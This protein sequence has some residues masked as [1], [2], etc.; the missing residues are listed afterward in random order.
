VLALAL[1][2][3][4]ANLLKERREYH[5]MSIQ[6]AGALAGLLPLLACAPATAVEFGLLDNELRGSLDSTVSYG[7]LWRVQGRDKTNDDVNVND[8]NRNFNP[9]TVSEVYKLTSDLEIS[10]KNVGMFLRGSGYYDSRIMDRRTHYTENNQPAQPGQ[11]SPDND[12][13][14]RDTRDSAGHRAEILDA[15]L[16][17]QWQVGSLPLGARLGRQV[18]NWGEGMFYRGGVNTTNPIDAAKFRLPGAELKEVLMPVEALNVTAGLGEN[19]SLEGFYQ[20]NWKETRLDPVGTYFS[21]TDLFARG[22][23]T[24]YAPLPELRGLN[25]LY[26]GMSALGVGGL[27]GGAGVD[28][29]GHLKVGSIGNDLNARNDGQFGLA[30]RYVAEQLNSTE[31]G[32]Y[33]VNYHAKEPTIHADLGAYQGL[34][35]AGLA[36]ATTPIVQQQ[37]AAQLGMSLAQLQAAISAQPNGPLAQGVRGAVS[38]AVAGMATLDVASQ[39]RGRRE[40]IEDIRMFGVSFNSN[41][42][43]ASVF[44]ELTYRPNMPIGMATTSDMLSDLLLQAPLLAGGGTANIGGQQASLGDEITNAEAVRMFNL[45]LGTV[46]DFGPHLGFDGLTGV[47]EV[48]SEHLRGSDLQYT[49]HDGSRRHYSSRAN[50]GYF[51]GFGDDAQI[52]PNA[53]GTTLMLVG[54]WNDLIGGANVS[55]FVIYKDDFKGNSHQTGNFIEGRKAYT[56]GVRANYQNRLEAELQYTEFYGGGQH[57]AVR[58]RDNLGVNLKYSF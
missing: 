54:T 43:R 31:F 52:T 38:Q 51:A 7:H 23:N 53:Y 13:F 29:S 21:E 49:A 12:H 40:Y 17:G 1:Q 22:G 44:G 42:G 20:F 39:V 27:Q 35:L 32:F 5:T 41:L 34:D 9:G 28:A 11:H 57:S 26:Q 18:F 30:L 8:G 24:A 55:P 36:A 2:S 56:L 19:V 4:A 15:Y 25:P 33:F 46:Y 50:L 14:S 58:D 45:S 3:S 6:R 48:A 10:Y 37:I 47:V 16:Y